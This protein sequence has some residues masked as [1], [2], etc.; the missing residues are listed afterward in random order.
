LLF[1]FGY[2]VS[3]ISFDDPAVQIKNYNPKQLTKLN[4]LIPK[5]KTGLFVKS[6]PKFDIIEQSFRMHAVIWFVFDPT[7]VSLETI[8]EFSFDKSVIVEKR[9]LSTKIIGREIEVMYDVIIDFVSDLNFHSFPFNDHKLILQLTNKK[10][11]FGEILLI[12][13][14]TMVSSSSQLHTKDWTYH[15]GEADYGYRTEFLHQSDDRKN[16]EYP[17]VVFYLSF[18]Q[19]GIKNILVIFLPLFIMFFL[20]LVSLLVSVDNSRMRMP[21]S[22]GSLS[23]LL[24]YRF[25]LESLTPKVGYFTI[26]D[27]VYLAILSASFISFLVNIIF[28]EKLRTIE[29]S[30]KIISV[31]NRIRNVIFYLLV[32]IVVFLS[33]FWIFT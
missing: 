7:F 14:S 10:I 21:I 25:I 20:S 17:I 3:I 28:V 11:S 1:S 2:R 32:S 4:K 6:Y 8:G 29:L 31:I 18:L 13:D 23:A 9:I 5:V 15:D 24:F 12:S 19:E 16:I 30:K 33:Y 22:I 27:K 26:S